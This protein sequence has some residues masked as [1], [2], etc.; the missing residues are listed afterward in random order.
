M[1]SESTGH[2]KMI[3]DRPNQV[4]LFVLESYIASI[5][6]LCISKKSLVSLFV[7]DT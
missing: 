3:T 6:V 7:L 4:S 1:I 2:P 5:H